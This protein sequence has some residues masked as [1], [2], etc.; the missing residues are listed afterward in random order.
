MK[1]ENEIRIAN[2]RL[3]Y[4]VV[5]DKNSLGKTSY[6]ISVSTTLFGEEETET[7]T[8]ISTDHNTVY[9]F[10]LILA[11][12]IVLPS[13]LNDIVNDYLAVL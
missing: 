7:V 8:D 10:M 5:K 3:I 2:G 6:G 12:N 11:D 13:T 1:T 4:R 9:E